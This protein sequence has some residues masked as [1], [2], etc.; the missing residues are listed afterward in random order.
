MKVKFKS[1]KMLI[2]VSFAKIKHLSVSL[3][4]FSFDLQQCDIIFA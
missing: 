2:L 3:I 4:L 1:L